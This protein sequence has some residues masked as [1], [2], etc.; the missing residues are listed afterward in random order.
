MDTAEYLRELAEDLARSAIVPSELVGLVFEAN[1]LDVDV[2]TKRKAHPSSYPP[3]RD[4]LSGI[5]TICA[6]D[7]IAVSQLR[8]ITFADRELIVEFA[9]TGE[10]GET[11]SYS[12]DTVIKSAASPAVSGSMLE[13][14]TASRQTGASA[15]REE[16]PVAG[17]PSRT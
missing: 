13:G 7:G 11:R 4:M 12:I 17:K 5:G 6:K 9:G 14:G 1:G 16:D 2:R 3:L 8:R 15:G 10:P